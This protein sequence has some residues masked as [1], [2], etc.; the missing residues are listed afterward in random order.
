MFF[1]SRYLHSPRVYWR[2]LR[3]KLRLLW[4]KQASPLFIL[5]WTWK[6]KLAAVAGLVTGAVAMTDIGEHGFAVVM[7]IAA[8][9]AFAI[10]I[11]WSVAPAH[12]ALTRWLKVACCIAAFGLTSIFVA[13]A[14][15][16][17][18]ATSW[19]NLS[20]VDSRPAPTLPTPTPF[21]AQTVILLQIPAPTVV[22]SPQPTVM[23]TPSA[24]LTRVPTPMLS[25]RK[26]RPPV[27]RSKRL[28]CPWAQAIRGKCRRYSYS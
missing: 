18:M 25:A 11:V 12:L 10:Q 6:K 16:R 2:A 13:I 20:N 7:L 9:A 5:F 19:S 26:S 24:T 1:S 14:Y 23:P 15:T 28:D 17:A 21:P 27:Q 4:I 22:A 8:F 3:I